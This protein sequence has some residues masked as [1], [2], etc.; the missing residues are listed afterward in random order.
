MKN[1][2]RRVFFT[3]IES[4]FLSVLLFVGWAGFFPNSLSRV[5]TVVKQSVDSLYW[6]TFLAGAAFLFCLSFVLLLRFLWR[7]FTLWRILHFSIRRIDKMT[8]QEF[9]VFLKAHFERM[10][11][12]AKTTKASNDYGA[13]LILRKKNLTICVQA[14]RYRSNIG[15]KAVQEVIGSMAYY[16]ADKGMVV[17]N[18]YFTKNAQNLALA[19]NI[20]LWDRDVLVHLLSGGNM[21]GYIYKLLTRN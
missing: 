10:G 15:V 7:R 8:G 17:T 3:I 21:G 14:K 6:P 2:I 18:S 4:L 1:Y 11:F 5:I 13:D 12:Y 20:I 9:E 19:N 16:K